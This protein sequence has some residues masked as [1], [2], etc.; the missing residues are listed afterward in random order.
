VTRLLADGRGIDYSFGTNGSIRTDQSNFSY[1]LVTALALQADGKIIAGGQGRLDSWHSTTASIVRYK[2]DAY[3][4]V[5]E[6][7]P[8]S[9][10]LVLYPN[11]AN[12]M[13]NIAGMQQS[14]FQRLEVYSMDGRL[15]TS[16]EDKSAFSV[17]ALYQGLYLVKVR[18]KTRPRTR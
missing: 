15:L 5:P 10:K 13:V 8:A 1:E 12:D 2:A 6:T 18:T 7:I 3:V 4:S 16:E 17:A 14:E 9:A 11:P